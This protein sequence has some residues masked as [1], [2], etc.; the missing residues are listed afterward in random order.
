MNDEKKTDYGV[1]QW[2]WVIIFGIAFAWV[3][4]A[5]VVYLRQIYYDGADLFPIVI[6]KEEGRIVFDY[7]MH[8]ELVREA[9]T[10]I[11]LAAI[12]IVAGRNRLQKF[13]YFMIVFGIWDIFYYVWLWVMIA[14]PE[15]LM[16]WDILFLLP[17][18]W[19]G[20]VITPVLIALTMVTAGTLLIYFDEKGADIRIRWFDWVIEFGCALLLIVAFCWDWKNIMQLSE[21]GVTNTG[22]PNPFA[23]WLYLP[24]YFFSVIYF[25]LRLRSFI[26]FPE[27]MTKT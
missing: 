18:P 15:S 25:A 5:V 1:R 4:S 10:L 14:W 17:L 8:I 7:L 9:A 12:G 26:G 6:V 3:E 13:C 23:W 19:V 22:I 2:G 21:G 24:A 16:T 11:M 20:P 27:K